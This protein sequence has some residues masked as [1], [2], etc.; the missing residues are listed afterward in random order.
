MKILYVFLVSAQLLF[1][2]QFAS[3]VTLD[4]AIKKYDVPVTSYYNGVSKRQAA[5][6]RIYNAVS[7][8]EYLSHMA[9]F[10]YTDVHAKGLQSD[11][12]IMAHVNSMLQLGNLANQQAQSLRFKVDDY[13]NNP[14][15]SYSIRTSA[16]SLITKFEA[17]RYAAEK[18]I[19]VARNRLNSFIQQFQTNLAAITSCKVA[20]TAADKR[21]PNRQYFCDEVPIGKTNIGIPGSAEWNSKKL[22][23][24]IKKSGDTRYN[25]QIPSNRFRVK[26]SAKPGQLISGVYYQEVC[27][28]IPEIIVYPHASIVAK[29]IVDSS[30]LSI[31]ARFR[32]TT[33]G[34]NMKG[35]NTC[36]KFKAFVE[37]SKAKVQMIAINP[38][39][40]SSV[41]FSKLKVEA[42]GYTALIL[43]VLNIVT[44]GAVDRLINKEINQI[45][46]SI[47]SA[48]S[49]FK[50]G[51]IFR[52]YMEKRFA[53]RVANSVVD[54]VASQSESV[55]EVSNPIKLND[56]DVP[57]DTNRLNLETHIQ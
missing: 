10:Y 11:A 13:I 5:I 7:D 14:D 57:H 47:A 20:G 23:A 55:Q 41:N 37:N 12:N 9:K 46:I 1:A 26:M 17:S 54:D 33:P 31:T 3:A 35:I 16:I 52:E 42:V 4:E 40:M 21:N 45:N 51:S 6:M 25:I 39:T 38:I 29:S 48:E 44:F 18:R 50:D 49:K 22:L 53:D 32:V 30:I 2:S 36:A 28:N 24:Q 56:G 19:D 8:L 34:A 15:L 27:L 43:D